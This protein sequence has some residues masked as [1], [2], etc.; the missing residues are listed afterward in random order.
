MVITS[1]QT[2]LEALAAQV[3]Q[4]AKTLNI[5]P[6]AQRNQALAYI[7]HNLL[8][9]KQEILAANEKDIAAAKKNGIAPA[10]VDR[11]TLTAARIEQIASACQQIISLPD[12]T[13]KT[14]F[15]ARLENGLEMVRTKVP[16]GVVGII[17]E[18][19]PN[20]TVDAAAL[21]LK[22]GNGCLLRGG[23]EA[24]HSNTA[25]TRIMQ[26]SL[27]QAGLPETA[28]ALVSD[29]ARETATQ[30][31]QLNGYLDVLI[32]RGGAGLIQSVVANATVPVIETGVGNCHIYV[33]A[34]ADMD[35]AVDVIDNAKTSRP[36][37]CN[38]VETILVHEAIAAEL[39]PKLKDRLD[40]H[41]VEWR[42][43]P[44]TKA[45]L[46]DVVLAATEKDFATEF[47]D[48]ILCCA[49]VGNMEEAIA[50]IDQYSS[51]HS[52][53]IITENYGR[54]QEFTRRVDAAVVYVNAS[55]RFT[56]GGEF[57]FGAEIGISTQKLHVRGPM[58]LEHLTSWKYII[59]GSGQIR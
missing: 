44:K 47:N 17:Y 43:C 58:G 18:A 45:I 39:L 29:T 23:K 24:I 40:K 20:V 22:S 7:A 54:S 1:M 4:G 2:P 8:E 15:G 21:C 35:M 30:M 38:A 55:T 57:G 3:K 25:L 32:P 34:D 33:D 11:L 46:G 37:V 41:Q 48:Y 42:G 12:P 14:D 16:L 19:R 26:E 13:G 9:R 59:R 56:D 31:M 52:E 51:H 49:V 5:A 10:M 6:I 28:V 50:H 53:A 36:S 27:A